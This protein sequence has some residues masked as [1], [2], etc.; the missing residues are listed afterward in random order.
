M[1]M[2]RTEKTENMR[3]EQLARIELVRFRIFS[4]KQDVKFLKETLTSLEDELERMG[5]ELAEAFPLQFSFNN[6]NR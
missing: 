6:L 3:D 2:R 4:A 5:E 1:E